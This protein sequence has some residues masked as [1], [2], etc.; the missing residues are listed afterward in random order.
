MLTEALLAVWAGFSCAP[1]ARTAY[2]FARRAERRRRCGRH[3]EDGE[4]RWA[5]AAVTENGRTTVTWEDGTTDARCVKE[6]STLGGE[7]D[8]AAGD[9]IGLRE[10]AERLLHGDLAVGEGV[11]GG[12]HERDGLVVSVLADGGHDGVAVGGEDERGL[13]DDGLE[14]AFVR[15]AGEI[16]DGERDERGDGQR[17]NDACVHE[18]AMPRGYKQVREA[19][20]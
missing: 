7:R 18:R 9:G 5:S 15:R 4:R 8:D 3:P 10:E 16:A 2:G 19:A 12:L 11:G 1:L 14:T 17:E 13:P 6:D 20:R